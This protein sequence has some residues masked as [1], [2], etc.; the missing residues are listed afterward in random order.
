MDPNRLNAFGPAYPRA[1]CRQY[2]D[3]LAAHFS[4]DGSLTANDGA[5]TVG[6]AAIAGVARGFMTAFPEMQ[7]TFDEFVV[8]SRCS[9]FRWTRT[10]TNTGLGRFDALEYAYQL[11]HA[12]E[13]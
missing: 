1:W 5:L 6:R 4:M 9:L 2:P 3:S 8:Q 12:V 11:E 13:G 7:V 10:S